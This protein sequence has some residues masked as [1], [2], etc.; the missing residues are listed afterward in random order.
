MVLLLAAACSKSGPGTSGPGTPD[1][2]AVILKVGTYNLWTSQ[3][4]TKY[5]S[6]PSQRFWK[7]SS[8]AMLAIVKDMDCDIFAFQEIC[9]SIYGKKGNATS[10]RYLMEK[11]ALGYEWAIWSNVDGGKVSLSS[12]K[13]SY[14]PGIVYKRSVLKLEDGGMFWLGG[15]PDKPEFSGFAP[16]DGADPRRACVWAKMRHIASGEVFYFLST[17]LD[18]QSYPEVN[19]QNC[20]NLMEHADTRIVPQGIPGIIAGDMNV[21]PSGKGYT[22]F[23]NNNSG[24]IHK[25]HNAYVYAQ[26]MNA[27]GPMAKESPATV[28]SAKEVTGTGRIDHILVTGFSVESYETLR[29]KYPTADGSMHYPSDHFPLIA[30]VVL[31]K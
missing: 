9:D 11:D 2:E 30:S 12:G 5:L 22:E 23:L 6:S 18:T 25:W 8:G 16:E 21:T 27:L 20:R 13:L 7:P 15:N 14:S 28:N 29:T 19:R 17:H 3:S 24:R 4:R 1:G 26:G 10:L 31:K